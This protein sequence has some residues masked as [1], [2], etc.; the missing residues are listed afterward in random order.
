MFVIFSSSE[1]YNFRLIRKVAKAN[2]ESPRIQCIH[3]SPL[4]L[5]L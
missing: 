2:L 1:R 5:P 4:R 3:S